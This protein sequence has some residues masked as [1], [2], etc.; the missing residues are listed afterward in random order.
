[1]PA[2]DIIGQSALLW[3]MIYR[4]VHAARERHPDFIIVR[5][6]DFARDP[7][8]GFRGLYASLGLDY[9]PRVEKI[10]LNSTSSDNPVELSR[11][12][13]HSVKLDS[14]A[15]IESW[16]KGLTEDE[17]KRVREITEDVSHV[18]YSD[19]EWP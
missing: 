10:I 2:N 6:K 8:N 12:K 17:I 14:L 5:H 7:V 11:T 15:S 1:V 9:T 19:S 3:K 4:S 18:Y 16:K 13:T